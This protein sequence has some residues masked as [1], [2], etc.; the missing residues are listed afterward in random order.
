MPM[1]IEYYNSKNKLIRVVETLDVEDIQGHPTA[2][3]S[4]AKDLQSGSETTLNFTDVG[5]DIGLTEDI[6]TERYLQRAPRK[7]LK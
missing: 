3:S 7:W 6:F 5:Y 1:K 4:I 2:T